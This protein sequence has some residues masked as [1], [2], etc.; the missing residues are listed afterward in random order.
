M[1]L[2]SPWQYML[3]LKT[4]YGILELQTMVYELIYHGSTNMV[5][6][7]VSE[8]TWGAQI[9]QFLGV[10]TITPL[11]LVGYEKIMANSALRASLAFHHLI[12]NTR[13]DFQPLFLKMS[14]RSSPIP[15][16]L[17]R[18]NKDRTRG[19]GGNRA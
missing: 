18:R 15:P 10:L 14:P 19:G 4:S 12:S 5:Q 13:L 7:R 2:H 16:L 3:I 8:K 1:R 17:S 9:L 6:A 11:A